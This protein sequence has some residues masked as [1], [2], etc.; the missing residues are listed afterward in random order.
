VFWAIIAAGL[1]YLI[2]A[3]IANIVLSRLMEWGDK[4]P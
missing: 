1:I 4:A 2:V 3:N